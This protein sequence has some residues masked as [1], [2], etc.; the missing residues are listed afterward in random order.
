MKRQR[1]HCTVCSASAVPLHKRYGA[2]VCRSCLTLFWFAEAPLESDAREAE[3]VPTLAFAE[4]K[5]MRLQ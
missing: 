5:K 3:I 4:L 2:S 1:E